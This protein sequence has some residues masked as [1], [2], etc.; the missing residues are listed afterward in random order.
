MA[1]VE[2]VQQFEARNEGM[3]PVAGYLAR[4]LKGNWVGV[5]VSRGPTMVESV[6]MVDKEGLP[7]LGRGGKQKEEKTY[8][9]RTRTSSWDC[10]EFP[11]ETKGDD[12]IATARETMACVEAYNRKYFPPPVSEEEV[13]KEEEK[14]AVVSRAAR[15]GQLSVYHEELQSCRKGSASY[16]NVLKRA[17]AKG[18]THDEVISGELAKEAEPE[19]QAS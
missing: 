7:V 6:P 12:D 14:K 5:L 16:G 11:P 2:V 8:K 18:F 4:T 10:E 15:E 17:E 9:T 13:K 3:S 19:G 1:N